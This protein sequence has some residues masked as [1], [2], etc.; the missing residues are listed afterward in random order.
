MVNLQERNPGFDKDQRLLTLYDFT[1]SLLSSMCILR[2]YKPL[3]KIKLWALLA[4]AW[5]PHVILF[6]NVW[7][8]LHLEHG[9]PLQP[10]ICL[11]F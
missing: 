6:L 4:E 10:F 11:G 3:L 7:L 1:L 5:S 9:G 2:V 8:S